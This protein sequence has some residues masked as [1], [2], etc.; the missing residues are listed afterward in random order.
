MLPIELKIDKPIYVGQAILDHSRF[1]MFDFYYN[2]LR[3]WYTQ[4]H[5]C[6]LLAT[7]TDSFKIQIYTDDVYRDMRAH[8]KHFDTCDYD[9]TTHPYFVEASQDEKARLVQTQACNKKKPGVFKDEINAGQ[10]V[11][12]VGLRSKVYSQ[13]VERNG[14]E[15]TKKRLK[16][17]KKSVVS[18]SISHEDYLATL[19]GNQKNWA[20]MT[21]I[22]SKKHKLALIRKRKISLSAFDDKRYLRNK[23]DSWA[24]GHK[25]IPRQ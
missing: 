15:S 12:F 13:K 11:E 19:M 20:K 23:V 14:E 1:I 9:S 2:Q 16:G 17:I 10:I 6:E 7:D 25:S 4:P 22:Q 8:S 24:Y 3:K 18:R 21:N 5:Q